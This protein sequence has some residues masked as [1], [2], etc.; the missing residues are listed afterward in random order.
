MVAAPWFQQAYLLPQV[1]SSMHGSADGTTSLQSTSRKVMTF[2]LFLLS[3]TYPTWG[4]WMSG[5]RVKV[6]S[7][8]VL[9]TARQEATAASM[10]VNSESPGVRLLPAASNRYA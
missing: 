8:Q 3:F 2:S 7:L 4:F 9:D 5:P 1:S 6:K 10:A